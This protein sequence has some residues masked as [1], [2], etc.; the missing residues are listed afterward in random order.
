MTL[1]AELALLDEARSALREGDR[2]AARA[3]LDRY[4][5]EIPRG[6]LGREAALLRDE[7]EAEAGIDAAPMDP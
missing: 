7:T 6:Q 3:L 4:A 5:R 2:A 1:A